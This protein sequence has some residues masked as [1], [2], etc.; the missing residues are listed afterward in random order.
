MSLEEKISDLRWHVATTGHREFAATTDYV[1]DSSSPMS[2]TFRMRHE[3][4]CGD[5]VWIISCLGDRSDVLEAPRCSY[6][7]RI[8]ETECAAAGRYDLAEARGIFG[9]GAL[10]E[11]IKLEPRREAPKAWDKVGA[12]DIGE[13][14]PV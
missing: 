12:L 7:V 5:H 9:I 6:E 13:D 4:G 11:S 8:C 14:D 1:F 3:D 2:Q 10:I